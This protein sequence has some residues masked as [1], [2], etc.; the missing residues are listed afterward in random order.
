[1]A[2]SNEIIEELLFSDKWLT[3]EYKN[4]TE[5]RAYLDKIAQDLKK[6]TKK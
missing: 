6:E 5:Y 4:S 3:D 1:M 2:N